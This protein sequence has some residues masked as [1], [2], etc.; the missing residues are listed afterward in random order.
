MLMNTHCDP[1]SL[2]PSPLSPSFP[3]SSPPPSFSLLSKISCRWKLEYLDISGCHLV[4]DTA[5]QKLA[6]SLVPRPRIPHPTSSHLGG[7]FSRG[8]GRDGGGGGGGGGGG[9]H[10]QLKC[11]ILSG[12]HAI[13]DK[14]LRY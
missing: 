4:T 8:G 9:D 1:L 14:G 6:Q 13:T 10:P 7:L 12:C 11:L 5:L 3:P 2:P